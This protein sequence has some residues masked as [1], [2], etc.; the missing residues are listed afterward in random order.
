MIRR[1]IITAG[2]IAATALGAGIA[3]AA[4]DVT[5]VEVNRMGKKGAIEVVVEAARGAPPVPTIKATIARRTRVARALNWSTSTSP[6]DTVTYVA[7]FPRLKGIGSG[8]WVSINACDST[9][10]TT[11][12]HNV[13]VVRSTPTTKR[14]ISDGAL[15]PLPVDAVDAAKAIAIALATVGAGSTLIGVERAN[16][17]GAVWKVTVLRVDGARVKVYVAPNG[18]VLAVRV[19]TKRGRQG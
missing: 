3:Q 5:S 6:T 13:T 11:T 10:C 1:T 12:R 9:G 18:N 17:M 8:V 16:E 14:S 4:P 15:P 7:R 19:E 2:V